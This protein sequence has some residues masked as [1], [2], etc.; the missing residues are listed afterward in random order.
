MPSAECAHVNFCFF[1]DLCLEKQTIY[2][3]SLKSKGPSLS[4]EPK[5][6]LH[7]K[8]HYSTAFINDWMQK[9]KHSKPVKALGMSRLLECVASSLY[10][11][12]WS[13][14][15]GGRSHKYLRFDVELQNATQTKRNKRPNRA[16][17]QAVCQRIQ[18][19]K[20]QISAEIF[21]L[22][23]FFT[24]YLTKIKTHWD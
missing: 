11:L 9:C 2:N 13:G 7:Q 12:S 3:R 19:E 17:N 10:V 16:G 14:S 1:V 21:H 15:K 20:V 24:S 5:T 23:F 6:L 22:Y 8:T 4:W 18:P